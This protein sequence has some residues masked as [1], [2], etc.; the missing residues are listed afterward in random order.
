MYEEKN[1]QKDNQKKNKEKRDVKSVVKDVVV[2]TL[3]T[4]AIIFVIGLGF[5]W[6]QLR[7]MQHYSSANTLLQTEDYEGAAELY[8]QLGDYED[9]QDRILYAEGMIALRSDDGAAALQKL[10]A[11][12][13]GSRELYQALQGRIR[14]F[15]SDWKNKGLS[16]DTLLLLLENSFKYDTEGKLDVNALTLEA[17]AELVED[18]FYAQYTRDLD[19]DGEEELICLTKEFTVKAYRM[20]PDKNQEIEL[21][22]E[23]QV[24]CFT[25]FGDNALEENLETAITCYR[26]GLEIADSPELEIRLSDALMEKS[27]LFEEAGDF[28]NA[29]YHAENAYAASGDK[30]AFLYFYGLMK[31]YISTLEEEEAASSWE[32]FTADYGEDMEIFE[33]SRDPEEETE[34]V[35]QGHSEEAD[36]SE[37]NSEEEPEGSGEPAEP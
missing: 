35:E 24:E 37:E 21:S 28:T 6:F 22:E 27:R 16:S 33:L 2:T 1:N 31:K 3:V 4:A 17:H 9:S 20:L 29:L 5:Y 25:D 10:D 7:P 14:A 26:K 32:Q 30:E 34:T 36:S 12:Q 18:D 19:E 23:Q 15:V 13:N 11:L 8:R